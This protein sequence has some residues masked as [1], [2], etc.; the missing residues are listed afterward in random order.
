MQAL[1]NFVYNVFSDSPT[2]EFAHYLAEL[3]AKQ[4][5]LHAKQAKQ[6]KLQP[7]SLSN[8]RKYNLRPRKPISYKV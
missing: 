7:L 6:A 4:A 1:F 3:E 8:P 5:K 2:D